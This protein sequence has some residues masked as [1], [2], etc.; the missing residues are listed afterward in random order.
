MKRS[1]IDMVMLCFGGFVCGVMA[2]FFYVS[3]KKAEI[4][5]P[6]APVVVPSEPSKNV[7]SKSVTITDDKGNPKVTLSANP[8]PAIE[9]V[10]RKGKATKLDLL[11]L[12]EMLK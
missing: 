12:L 9:V 8:D 5:Q 11:K 7:F 4:A 6:V 10:D 2:T 1:L 3:S